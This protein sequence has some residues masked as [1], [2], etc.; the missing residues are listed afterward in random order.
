MRPLPA[1][2]L[3]FSPELFRLLLIVLTSLSAIGLWTFGIQ[4][5]V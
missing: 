4:L 1:S 2:G 3:R 5:T